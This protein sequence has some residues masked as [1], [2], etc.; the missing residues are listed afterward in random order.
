MGLL[1][2]F[3]AAISAADSAELRQL[4]DDLMSLHE[5]PRNAVCDRSHL[6]CRSIT[7]REVSPGPTRTVPRLVLVAGPTNQDG[8][9]AVMSRE[10]G[11]SS[12]SGHR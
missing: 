1:R 2:V 3:R 9:T 11:D 8:R 10:I 4:V 7:I 12:A 5:T 6:E